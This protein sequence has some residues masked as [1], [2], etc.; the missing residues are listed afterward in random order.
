MVMAGNADG[1]RNGILTV[2]QAAAILQVRP[3]TVR[4]LASGQTLK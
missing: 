3:K 1:N 4:D 2:E